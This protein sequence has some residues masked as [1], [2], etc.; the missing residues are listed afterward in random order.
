MNT[1]DTYGMQF[2]V[3]LE[4]RASKWVFTRLSVR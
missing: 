2:I 4:K 3:R 1:A